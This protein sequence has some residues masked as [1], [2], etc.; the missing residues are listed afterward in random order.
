[1]AL[2]PTAAVFEPPDPVVT[3]DAV[4]LRASRGVRDPLGVMGFRGALVS[5]KVDALRTVAV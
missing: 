1:M 5:A 4:A 3:A 2:P